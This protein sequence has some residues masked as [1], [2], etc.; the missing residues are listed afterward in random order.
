MK[1]LSAAEIIAGLPRLLPM[2]MSYAASSGSLLIAN[3]AQLVT[4]AILAR[5]FGAVE[6]GVF[7]SVTAVTSIAVHLC[8][9]GASEC[10]VRRVARDH[11][12]YPVMMGHNLILT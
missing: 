7:V 8:G 3:A 6:F 11:A 5:S 4:F 1:K 10:L 2:I 9:L 12:M